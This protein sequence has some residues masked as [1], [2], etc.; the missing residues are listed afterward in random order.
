MQATQISRVASATIRIILCCFVIPCSL[1]TARS[2]EVA[3]REPSV[4][5]HLVY[6]R[7]KDSFTITVRNLGP[8]RVAVLRFR[9][10]YVIRIY[11]QQ[12]KLLSDDDA[13]MRRIQVAGPDNWA[14]VVLEPRDSVSFELYAYNAKGRMLLPKAAHSADCIVRTHWAEPHQVPVFVTEAGAN[15]VHIRSTPRIRLR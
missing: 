5:G 10:M 14:W 9:A 6:S 2:A 3:E 8:H 13:F 7:R 15:A 4:V 1:T 11:D 12:G